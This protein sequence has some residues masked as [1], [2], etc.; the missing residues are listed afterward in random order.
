MSYEYV[1][2]VKRDAT[3]SAKVLDALISKGLKPVAVRWKPETNSVVIHFEEALSVENK[4]K[5]DKTMKAL[6]YMVT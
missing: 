6:G 1:S 4:E 2:K 5:L 3:E